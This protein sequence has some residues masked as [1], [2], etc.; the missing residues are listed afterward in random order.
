[1]A[2]HRIPQHT[3]SARSELARTYRGGKCPT[4][5]L[6]WTAALPLS[7]VHD[8]TY[9][10]LALS[11]VHPLSLLCLIAQPFAGTVLYT[12]PSMQ[13]LLESLV[14]TFCSCGARS[15]PAPVVTPPLSPVLASELSE[16]LS[17]SGPTGFP[18]H[19]IS[20]TPE[21]LHPIVACL[22]PLS[23]RASSS[24]GSSSTT[25]IPTTTATS[26]SPPFPHAHVDP[27]PP[28]KAPPPRP[29]LT[30][31]SSSS[32]T[33]QQ[34]VPLDRAHAGPTHAKAPPPAA[35]HIHASQ[36]ERRLGTHWAGY[37][38][39]TFS[40]HCAGWQTWYTDD[41]SLVFF[42]NVTTGRSQWSP[43]AIPNDVDGTTGGT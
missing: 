18:R 5:P 25:Q 22:S 4:L 34:D 6:R 26:K 31:P 15:L 40:Q 35:Y 14:R 11:A 32:S 8:P 27:A 43:P 16:T 10:R 1:M 20:V 3:S 36:I 38:F 21:S 28:V 19:G 39:L 9:C 41:Y 24:S 29:P 33:V 37:A 30:Q 12:T 42:Y 13:W 17:V 23:S 2:I 7:H